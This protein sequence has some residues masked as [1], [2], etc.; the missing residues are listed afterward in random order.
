MDLS[1]Y[2]EELQTT[3]Y[4]SIVALCLA[5][6]AVLFV[7]IRRII[8]KEEKTK[9]KIIVWIILILMF[10]SVLNQFLVGPY[11]AKKEVDQKTIYCYEGVF[12]IIET[13]N[14]IYAKAVFRFDNQELTLKYSKDDYGE[15]IP[16]RYD[17][18]LIYAQ[19]LAQILYLEME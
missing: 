14:G 13:S 10:A 4:L 5:I 18:K 9:T 2:Y 8:N 16:G 7:G 6:C 12:E 19:H 1:T 17:G 3:Y 11:L 15:I